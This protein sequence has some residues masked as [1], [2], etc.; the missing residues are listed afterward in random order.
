MDEGKESGIHIHCQRF[1]TTDKSPVRRPPFVSRLP[2]T[3]HC[4]TVCQLLRPSACI[5]AESC[6]VLLPQYNVSPYICTHQS[7]ASFGYLQGDQGM[8]AHD[9]SMQVV[10]WRRA[11]LYSRE[12]RH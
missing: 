10:T 3:M 1:L 8:L 5:Y 11:V 9:L 12:S 7:K 4:C 6:I 2:C